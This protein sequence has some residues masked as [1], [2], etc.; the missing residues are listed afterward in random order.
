MKLAPGSPGGWLDIIL[1]VSG[2]VSVDETD[3]SI[4]GLRKAYGPPIVGV[5]DPIAER[6][7]K[8]EKLRK[9]SL[10]DLLS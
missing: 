3:T 9:V 7:K 10:P 6:R 4:G 2:R 1:G 5:P 8:T